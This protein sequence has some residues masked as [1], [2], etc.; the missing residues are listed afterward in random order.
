VTPQASLVVLLRDIAA[1]A[2]L[3]FD[4]P[5]LSSEKGHLPMT[6][7]SATS[8]TLF[9][10]CNMCLCWLSKY[11]QIGLSDVLSSRR[12]LGKWVNNS[13]TSLQRPTLSSF[14][15]PLIAAT[16]LSAGSEACS[17]S[18]PS[19]SRLPPI[20]CQRSASA[21]G[22]YYS[23]VLMV[24]ID[25]A[26]NRVGTC[27]FCSHGVQHHIDLLGWILVGHQEG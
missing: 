7:T 19:P 6:L 24:A 26:L 9:T 8:Y 13:S 2:D 23:P 11:T 12:V 18:D 1:F 3:A 10:R 4:E 14:R 25:L 15:V 16:A 5:A 27:P 22:L 17:S 20:P 21:V